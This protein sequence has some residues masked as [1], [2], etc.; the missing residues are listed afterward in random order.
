[1]IDG[2]TGSREVGCYTG[3]GSD[4]GAGGGY[5]RLLMRA[6]PES[7]RAPEASPRYEGG[8]SSYA[9]KIALTEKRP[10]EIRSEMH[11]RYDERPAGGSPRKRKEKGARPVLAS[12]SKPS[13]REF[14]HRTVT[15]YYTP[16]R[17]ANFEKSPDVD[18]RRQ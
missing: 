2:S 1:M 5:D 6:L 14:F 8:S 11:Y 16:D 17:R 12:A 7:R 9:S 15:A 4:F 10:V 3:R 18:T 13:R